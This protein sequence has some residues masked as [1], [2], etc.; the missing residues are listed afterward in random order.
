MDARV[1]SAWFWAERA[2][3]LVAFILG[4]WT[5]LDA[6][7]AH[8]YASLPVPTATQATVAL[9]GDPGD[10]VVGTGTPA[11]LQ[12]GSW[13]A[14]IQIPSIGLDA[15]VIEGSTDEMLAR[16]AGHIEYTPLPG[17]GGN[18]GIAGHRDTT[19]RP[20]RQVQPGHALRLVTANGTFEYRVDR[21]MVVNPDAVHVL[22][23]TDR[24]TVTLVT[25]YPFTFVGR[26]PKRFIVQA[27]RVE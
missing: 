6:A 21:T 16:A 8:F 19:F 13:V 9:P 25:C 7:E 22:D 11:S 23:P 2:L 24:P 14:R 3:F 1:R 26:A 20:L 17:R 15:T 27:S 4:T 5:L 10:G 18:V 12:P